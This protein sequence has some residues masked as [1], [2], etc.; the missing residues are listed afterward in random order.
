MGTGDFGGKIKAIADYDELKQEN[1]SLKADVQLLR[2]QLKSVIET[3]GT[4][5]IFAHDQFK[6]LETEIQTLKKTQ[7]V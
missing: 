3:L 1:I 7:I 4:F 2:S 5:Q 6:K